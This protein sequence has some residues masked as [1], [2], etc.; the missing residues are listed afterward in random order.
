MFLKEKAA[1]DCS[2]NNTQQSGAGGPVL[3]EN[4]PGQS[5]SGLSGNPGRLQRFGRYSHKKG[6]E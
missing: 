3:S 6:E 1:K 5:G 4:K 2:Q